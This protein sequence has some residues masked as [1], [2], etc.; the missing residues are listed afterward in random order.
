MALSARV[1]RSSRSAGLGI[2]LPGRIVGGKGLPQADRREPLTLASWSGSH[3]AGQGNETPGPTTHRKIRALPPRS[4]ACPSG[5]DKLLILPAWYLRVTSDQS[6]CP[7][8]DGE[9]GYC[10]QL[11]KHDLCTHRTTP[12]SDS[13][14]TYLVSRSGAGLNRVWVGRPC[15]WTCSCPCPKEDPVPD[16]TPDDDTQ[17]DLF[18]NPAGDGILKRRGGRL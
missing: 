1:G 3:L 2:A 16:A 9:C 5:E 15:R 13:P 7:C 8:R 11:G 6:I 17:L 12:A 4:E 10:K 18:G 14:E